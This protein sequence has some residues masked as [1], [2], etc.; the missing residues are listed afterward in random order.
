MTNLRP[1]EIWQIDT[2]NADFYHFATDEGDY[3]IKQAELELQRC[4][5]TPSVKWIKNH[6]SLILWK[7]GGV[8]QAQPSLI[9]ELWTFDEA[10]KQLK[11]RYEREISSAQRPLVRRIQ[12]HDSSPSLS[13]VLCVVAIHRPVAQKNDKGEEVPVLPHLELTDGWYRILAQLDGCL[14]RAVDKG[15][16]AVGRK[17][18]ITGAKLDSGA[19]GAEVMDAFDKSRLVLSGNSTSLAKWDA[20]L[21]MQK[22]PFIATLSSLSVDGGIVTMM[23]VVIDKVFPLAFRNADWNV[24]EGEWDQEEETKRQNKWKVSNYMS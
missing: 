11:Y 8:I 4:G 2:S 6:W 24:R 21:G 18:G 5:A 3:G 20:K 22:V 10:V 14:A 15:K 13:M 23:D 12:E 9:D 17:L 16:I 1:P 7:L 19:D